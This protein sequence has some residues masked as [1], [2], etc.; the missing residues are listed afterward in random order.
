MERPQA[1]SKS[2]TPGRGRFFGGG[3]SPTAAELPA[4]RDA[5]YSAGRPLDAATRFFM[6]PRFGRD[7]SD[8]RVH[9]DARADAAA[10]AAGARA[11]T[12]GSDIVFRQGEFSEQTGAGR[13][14]LAH[15]LA[16]TIQQGAPRDASSIAESEEAAERGA[17]RAADA[18]LAGRPVGPPLA[19]GV[20]V[21]RQP[22]LTSRAE[23]TL[24]Q[25]GESVLRTCASILASADRSGRAGMRVVLMNK[26]QAL[27]IPEMEVLGESGQR[28]ANAAAP[29][30][31][32]AAADELRNFVMEVV[33]QYPGVYRA[34][35]TRDQQGVMRLG[36]WKRVGDA[37]TA[38]A[39]P[40]PQPVPQSEDEMLPDFVRQAKKDRLAAAKYQQDVILHT[41]HEQD[42]TRLK[43]AIW[44]VAPVAAVK[45]VG[46]VGKATG[47]I[48]STEG[49]VSTAGRAE[50]L[51]VE[52]KQARLAKI[53]AA[54]EERYVEGTI[55]ELEVVEAESQLVNRTPGLTPVK[56]DPRVRGYAHED[57][58]LQFGE[59][60]ATPPWFKTIDGYVVDSA[61]K[62]WTYDYRGR[63]ILVYEN[64]AV[65]SHKS[66]A[67]TDPTRLHYKIM[68][69]ID[70]L[71]G[72]KGYR[73]GN[74]EIRGA[75][76][77]R[78][79]FTI[80]EDAA[81][82]SS[83]VNTL[84]SWRT[85]LHDIQ[86]EWYVSRGT[87]MIPGPQYMKSLSLTDY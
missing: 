48:E 49:M 74:I 20:R 75:G 62:P 78:L 57:V 46:K 80:D 58:V 29:L 72:F 73:L 18:A 5:L 24:K 42:P 16:H 32:S 81:L 25:Q 19:T 47:V 53:R 60:R 52:A 44:F 1:A 40:P 54:A 14:L 69:D 65:V 41:I 3:S 77:R 6:E 87:E 2:S 83:N 61:A 84:E 67:I 17:D 8:V 86:F 33:A 27:D 15:E 34:E 26:G 12:V 11:F 43:N 68:E 63:T 23:P 22:A 36:S 30:S 85:N 45:V 28:P 10:T 39:P 9:T 38:A 66:T 13:A 31:E 70:A 50:R 59:Y 71:R 51:A 56:V 79:V 82:E 35:I 4:A 76:A 55:H 64:P 37:P 7:F 21:A